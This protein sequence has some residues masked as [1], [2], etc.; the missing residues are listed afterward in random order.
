M[1]DKK[2]VLKKVAVDGSELKNFP[3]FHNDKKVVLAAVQDVGYALEYASEELRGDREIVLAAVQN[4]GYALQHASE[5]LRRDRAIVLTAVRNSATMIQFKRES[6]LRHA[7]QEL[8]KDREIILE[9]VKADGLYLEYVDDE[10]K[11]DEELVEIAIATCPQMLKYANENQRS[12]KKLAAKAV[13]VDGIALQYLAYSLKNDPKIVLT[14]VTNNGKA[15]QYASDELRKNKE[16]VE[17]AIENDA[18]AALHTF[19]AQKALEKLSKQKT[20]AFEIRGVGLEFTAGL[21]DKK[22]ASS[23]AK[24]GKLFSCK[25]SVTLP[26]GDECEVFEADNL[27]HLHAADAVKSSIVFIDNEGDDL[28]G[29]QYKVS[30]SAYCLGFSKPNSKSN[31]LCSQIDEKGS[32]GNYKLNIDESFDYNRLVFL[33]ISL[34]E[35]FDES[36]PI[37]T[38]TYVPASVVEKVGDIDSFL[39]N[40]VIE[41]EEHYGVE[42][43][44]RELREKAL[45]KLGCIVPKSEDDPSSSSNRHRCIIFNGD[46]MED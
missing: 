6:V 40:N 44:H 28:I 33:S 38:V 39:S 26:S 36:Y 13:N 41:I 31:I 14:A 4:Y 2:R 22:W 18:S 3:E 32:W 27:A 25:G 34:D 24:P 29:L 19:D 45:Q 37:S 20:I 9:A 7:S 17:A 30:V 43:K 5:A 1:A 11:E 10:F 42:E 15:L 21:V 16:I 23:V 12:N 46:Y 35:V 8:Q